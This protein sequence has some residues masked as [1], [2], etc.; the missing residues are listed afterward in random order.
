MKSFFPGLL[1]LVFSVTGCAVGLRLVKEDGLVKIYARDSILPHGYGNQILEFK[2]KRYHRLAG[3]GYARIPDKE[4]IVFTTSRDG[5]RATLHV[6]PI[7]AGEGFEIELRGTGFG[8]GLGY[9]KEDPASHYVESVDGDKIVFV[10]KA[11]SDPRGARFVLDLRARTLAPLVENKAKQPNHVKTAEPR[12]TDLPFSP[13]RDFSG[14]P[15]L[16]SEEKPVRGGAA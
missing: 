9:P 5:S 8:S 10:A 7:G 3:P 1:L 2:G 12:Q 15:E 11:W 14:C 16:I 4:F 13:R 6:I